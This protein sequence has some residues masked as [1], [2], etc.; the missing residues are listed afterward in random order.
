M[1]SEESSA[2]RRRPHRDMASQER[3]LGDGRQIR[4]PRTAAPD[5]RSATAAAR[6]TRALV[7]RAPQAA[8]GASAPSAP[9]PRRARRAPSRLR[10]AAGR[11]PGRAVTADPDEAG[12]GM[13]D[14]P[15]APLLRNS[16]L[17]TAV[18]SPSAAKAGRTW[19]QCDHTPI[20]RARAALAVRVPRSLAPQIRTMQRAYPLRRP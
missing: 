10:L 9:D 11:P 17:L 1:Q 19:R 4:R 8:T 18:V 20:A 3:R 2:R 15:S 14:A 13:A 5:P 16:P 6:L 12:A 7:W